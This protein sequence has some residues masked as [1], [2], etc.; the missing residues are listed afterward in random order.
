MKNITRLLRWVHDQCIELQS[1][2]TITSSHW[3]RLPSTNL[4]IICTYKEGHHHGSVTYSTR[5]LVGHCCVIEQM[6]KHLRRAWTV[7]T[8]PSKTNISV[9]S[10]SACSICFILSSCSTIPF[11]FAHSDTSLFSMYISSSALETQHVVQKQHGTFNTLLHS[12]SDPRHFYA[13][14]EAKKKVYR[15]KKTSEWERIPSLDLRLFVLQQKT[16][17]TMKVGY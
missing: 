12:N 3:I 17:N 1:L 4:E 5:T 10:L 7:W 2:N 16:S 13:K 8:Q 15:N 6:T 11:V 14:K 9:F